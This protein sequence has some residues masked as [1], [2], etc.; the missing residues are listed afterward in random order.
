[1]RGPTMKPTPASSGLISACISPNSALRPFGITFSN[2]HFGTSVHSFAPEFRNLYSAPMP[3]PMN[4]VRACTPRSSPTIRTSAH[5]VPSGYFSVRCSFTIS[6][7]RSGIMSSTPSS[8]P[9]SDTAATSVQG[10]S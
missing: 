6:E 4:T 10:S 9:I 5:A 2:V 3:K 8:P 7:S 1:M